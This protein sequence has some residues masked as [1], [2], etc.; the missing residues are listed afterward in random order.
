MYCP[1][2]EMSLP[3]RQRGVA[4]VV[5]MLV[6]A[7]CAALLVALQRDFTLAY[8]RA[9]NRFVAEQS[10]SYLR[11]AEE[12]AA[13][14]LR[15]DREADLAREAPRDD[16]TEVWAQEAT[17][18]ALDE[19]GWMMG[20]LW[21]LQG[22][23]NLNSLVVQTP[24]GDAAGAT[25]FAPAQQ[26]FIRLLQTFEELPLTEYEA[27]AI[28]ESV[29]DWLDGDG[30]PR[31]NG[32]ETPVYASRTPP[33]RPANAPMRDVSE[34]R[35]VANISPELYLLLQ[36]LVT[37]WP[38]DGGTI[39]IHTAPPN[40]LRAL[41]ALGGLQP[42][43]EADGD[44]LLQYRTETGFVD[45]DDFLAQPVFSGAQPDDVTALRALLGESSAFFLLD[46]RVEIAD[47][48]QRLYSV[49]RREGR[50]VDVLL[51]VPG[52]L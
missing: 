11:G 3:R 32:A 45:I 43:T 48:E 30:N 10:W 23:F 4:L 21:D 37:V 40:L 9:S 20:A 1:V 6:F 36:P 44:S 12:L 26:V 50:Q 22:R 8:Q 31:M 14:A 19:G 27:I 29:G 38:L 47:R 41:N 34:L 28:T 15:V 25:R 17:P 52:V 39:N 16:L 33:Y 18:Y 24:G 49:L 5:A 51:R 42:L 7:I 35:A 13:L 2:A 46:A